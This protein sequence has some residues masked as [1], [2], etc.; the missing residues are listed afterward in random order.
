MWKVL[1]PIF[2]ERFCLISL[3]FLLRNFQLFQLFL[4][5]LFIDLF[6]H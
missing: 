4:R 3:L 5:Y 1:R 2:Q 6:I